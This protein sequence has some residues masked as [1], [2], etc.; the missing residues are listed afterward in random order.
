M[1]AAPVGPGATDPDGRFTLMA[2]GRCAGLGR[3]GPRRACSLLL[4][5]SSGYPIQAAA[6]RPER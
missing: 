5:E 4:V 6:A 1:Y 2:E 3:V